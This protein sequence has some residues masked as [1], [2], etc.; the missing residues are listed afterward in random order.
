MCFTDGEDFGIWSEESEYEDPPNIQPQLSLEAEKQ[1]ALS[2]WLTIVILLLHVRY[3][4][5]EV[6][7]SRIF[8]VLKVLLLILGRFCSFAAN[9]AT[10]FSSNIY[11]AMEKQN[12]K[13]EHFKRYVVCKKC[14]QVYHFHECFQ[15]SGANKRIKSCLY[16]GLELRDCDTVLLKNVEM[17]TGKKVFMPLLTYCYVDLKTSMQ[18]LLNNSDFVE[19]CGQWRNY[20][21]SNDMLRSVYDGNVWKEFLDSDNKPFFD[22]QYHYGFI[23]NLDWFQLLTYSV[24]F[25]LPSKIEYSDAN[26]LL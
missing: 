14:H 2:T 1:N 5:A 24:G 13:T 8:S 10:A 6:M 15:G 22:G 11:Q 4:L 18:R 7:T 19:A 26:N 21:S 23:L 16:R 12:M 25:I 20:N 3:H 9:V 17:S